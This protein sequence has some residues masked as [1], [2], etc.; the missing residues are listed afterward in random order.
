MANIPAAAANSAYFILL[1]NYQY[2]HLGPYIDCP[3]STICCVPD[4][5]GILSLGSRCLTLLGCLECL[6]LSKD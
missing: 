2:V 4:R 5:R 1:V 6:L 3:T